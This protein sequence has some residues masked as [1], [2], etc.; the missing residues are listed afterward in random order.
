MLIWWMPDWTNV[1]ATKLIIGA[2][3]ALPATCL[4]ICIHL[5]QISSSRH[6]TFTISD[7][8]RR[9]LFEAGMCIGL[10][11]VFMGLRK[12]KWNISC[13][14]TLILL[15][16]EDYIVQGH[17]FDI[18]ETYGC[19]PTTYFSIPSIFLIWIPPILMSM[20]A[21]IYAGLALRHFIIRR[22]SFAA[23][24]QASSSALTTSRYIRLMTMAAIQMVWS[25]AA[26]SYSLWFTVMSVPIR[27][28][29]TWSDVHSDWLR[30]DQY[31]YALIPVVVKRAF[32]VVWWI[33]PS[34]TFIFVAFF[35][36][37]QD[38]MDEYKRCFRWIYSKVFR[39]HLHVKSSKGSFPSMPM[40]PTKFHPGSQTSDSISPHPTKSDFSDLSLPPYDSSDS[41]YNSTHKAPF[42][43]EFDSQSDA[44]RYSRSP[45]VNGKAIGSYTDLSVYTTSTAGLASPQDYCF[46]TSTAL[47]TS[48]PS[49]SLTSD[50][51]SRPI[52]VVF[53]PRRPLT[54]PNHDFSHHNTPVP[55]S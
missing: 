35:A 6:S 38:A 34:S 2:N 25:I 12:S 7:K 13:L 4:C 23:H 19:R 10:P 26:T 33:V 20:A 53:P 28:W 54:Y 43:R 44:T 11:I 45:Y 22:L 18:I 3:F 30:I 40:S 15:R 37:G 27:P 47:E 32:N 5:E 31:P 16:N 52:S 51:P 48:P 17:R 41:S 42:P 49:S 29:T 9:Q 24:L 8:R 36:F 50:S 55:N 46:P 14:M 21:I 1:K 39:R